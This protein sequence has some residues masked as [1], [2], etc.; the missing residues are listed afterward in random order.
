M[1]VVHALKQMT[2]MSAVIVEHVVADPVFFGMQVVRRFPGPVTR[3]LGAVLSRVPLEVTHAVGA[4]V[5]GRHRD[6][7]AL[8]EESTASGLSAGVMGELA[9]H[10]GRPELARTIARRAKRPRRQ[11][12]LEARALWFEGHMSRAVDVAPPGGMRERLASEV[13]TFS[14][15][16]HPLSARSVRLPAGTY[17][18][19]LD[20]AFLLNNSV[21][22][23]QSG[24]TIRSHEALKALTAAGLRVGAVTKT[25]YPATVGRWSA[26][27]TQLVDGVPYVH[28][29]PGWLART[30]EAR[31][32]QQIDFVTAWV[33]ATGAQVLHTTTHFTNGMVAREVAH[34]AGIPWVYEVRGILENTWA[35][36]RNVSFATAQATEK[37]R[38]FRQAETAVA[39]QADHVVTLGTPM[40][41]DLAARGVPDESIIVV[42]NVVGE[43]VMRAYLGKPAADVRTQM[44]LPREG[45]WV[46]SAASI[47]DYEGLDTLVDAVVVLRERGLDVR[48]LI[49][50]D[51]VAL[52]TLRERAKPLGEFAVFPGRV[53]HTQAVKYVQCLDVYCIPRTDDPVCR[54]VSP[55]KPI[56]ACALGRPLVVSDVPGLTASV[57]SDC[58][59]EVPPGSVHDL[60]VALAEL[61]SKP[62]Q[63]SAMGAEGVRWVKHNSTWPL[64]ARRYL[65]LYDY[66]AESRGTM[67]AYHYV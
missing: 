38:L 6:T 23:T 52:P 7:V 62:R 14:P 36:S 42:P 46:G 1:N 27:P 48:L 17:T 40:K 54:L 2:S 43:S 63:L 29:I 20:V 67:G 5:Q 25:G 57:P 4:W 30:P 47:V 41:E 60:A 39:L 31:L 9:L 64:M 49:V 51:G 58:Y 16:W 61:L 34:R 21:P 28:Q 12:K 3:G 13:R 44:G 19:P 50:G 18:E 24:Y 59:S 33:R 55:L 11:A 10:M 15:Q 53:T 32:V 66:L 35:S 26:E 45:F 22:F 56:E 65:S 37:Y 8:L